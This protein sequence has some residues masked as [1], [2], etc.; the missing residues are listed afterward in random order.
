MAAGL[1]ENC[2]VSSVWG[3][4]YGLPGLTG[5]SWNCYAKQYTRYSSWR[6]LWAAKFA[7]FIRAMADSWTSIQII[8]ERRLASKFFVEV[9]NSCW[10]TTFDSKTH[11]E[12]SYRTEMYVACT[13]WN[14][15][16]MWDFY[17]TAQWMASEILSLLIS[18]YV[19]TPHHVTVDA[20][21][22]LPHLSLCAALF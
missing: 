4:K 2:L 3:Y 19:W 14:S 17:T 16:G 13:E 20:N 18:S 6:K 8:S 12:S 5:T 15:Q 22:P 1:N 10:V 9:Y 21:C 7:V 11:V